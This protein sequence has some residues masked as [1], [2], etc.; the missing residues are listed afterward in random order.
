VSVGAEWRNRGGGNALMT[1]AIAWARSTGVVR[2][3]ELVVFARNS[4]AIHLYEKFG[5]VVEGRWRQTV[6]R[7]G[8]YLDDLMMA[9]LL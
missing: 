1:Q 3:M 5:F 2:R 6:Y 9:L 4:A 7:N 8:E